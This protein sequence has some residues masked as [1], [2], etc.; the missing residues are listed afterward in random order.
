MSYKLKPNYHFANGSQTGINKVPV[1][2]FV[3][4]ESFGN[5]N[6]I[7]WYKKAN[8]TGL[9]DATTIDQAVSA[10]NLVSPIDVKRNI[11]DSYSITEV[12]SA[13]SLK[14]NSADVYGR[15]ETD[16]MITVASLGKQPAFVAPPTMSIGKLG[17]S[18]G[19]NAIDSNYFYH[20]I[21]NYDGT[22]DIWARVALTTS[23]W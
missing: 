20:C 19:M 8:D 18:A 23:T 7:K 15:A 10:G 6:E 2:R 5:Y 1:G 4:V 16:A 3:V 14:A 11:A 22:T 9:T 17:D 12:D 21:A 13:L